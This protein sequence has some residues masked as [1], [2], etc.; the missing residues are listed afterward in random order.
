[1]CCYPSGEEGKDK[2]IKSKIYA[3]K[4]K[5][6]VINNRVILK[7][8]TSEDVDLKTIGGNGTG[9]RNSR[10]VDTSLIQ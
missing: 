7:T 1:M 6:N 9:G 4:N 8:T 3:V 2:C 5:K 10:E